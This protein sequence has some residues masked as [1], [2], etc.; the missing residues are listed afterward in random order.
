[1]RLELRDLMSP[2]GI[3]LTWTNAQNPVRTDRLIV[4]SL[5]GN[6]QAGAGSSGS[7]KDKTPLASTAIT[8]GKVL[9]FSWVDC[10]A[11]NKFLKQELSSRSTNDRARIFG[12]AMARLL[13]HEFYHVLTQTEAHTSVGVTKAS[14]STAD[15][16]AA[17]FTFEPEAISHLQVEPPAV[18]LAALD[19]TPANSEFEL[20]ESDEP[21]LSGR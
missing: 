21:A 9:P 4:I 18:T 14:F 20:L 15:L 8:D 1:M 11:L 5:R 10:N 17:N 2:T 13:A 12:R 6:C 3:N 7:F 16:L 19:Q